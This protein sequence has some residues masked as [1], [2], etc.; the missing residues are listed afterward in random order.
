MSTKPLNEFI[1]KPNSTV[2]EHTLYVVQVFKHGN[3]HLEDIIKP[4]ELYS[5]KF[6]LN[7]GNINW[8]DM[9]L[10]NYRNQDVA[11]AVNKQIVDALLVGH[12]LS[13]V[14]KET[15]D[16]L[17]NMVSGYQIFVTEVKQKLSW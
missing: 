5:R 14:I 12:Q 17:P 11:G 4:D 10:K 8:S 3:L 16:D 2:H 1:T 13:T 6:E 9:P 15:L 7:Y